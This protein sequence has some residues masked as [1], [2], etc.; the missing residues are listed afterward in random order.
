[1]LLQYTDLD[2]STKKSF[3]RSTQ[4]TIFELIDR[5]TIKDIEEDFCNGIVCKRGSG[6]AHEETWVSELG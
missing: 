4:L 6:G 1:M 3:Y 5:M 2:A